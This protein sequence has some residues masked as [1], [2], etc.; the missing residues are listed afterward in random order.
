MRSALYRAVKA[1]NSEVFW[2][3]TVTGIRGLDSRRRSGIDWVSQWLAVSGATLRERA[4][5]GESGTRAVHP[6][7]RASTLNNWYW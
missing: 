6:L 7:S 5:A 2:H 1:G 3:W 4:R